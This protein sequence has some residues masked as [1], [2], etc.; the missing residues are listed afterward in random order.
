MLSGQAQAEFRLLDLS[1]VCLALCHRC[2]MFPLGKTGILLVKFNFFIVLGGNIN[3]KSLSVCP[4]GS[5]AKL[6][7][8][9][10]LR[11][12]LPSAHRTQPPS[13]VTSSELS[14]R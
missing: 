11:A 12:P 2:S 4:F 7:A 8:G 9:A 14:E 5:P 1:L 10:G 3:P 13:G 6:A